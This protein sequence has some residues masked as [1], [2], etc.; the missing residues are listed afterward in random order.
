MWKHQNSPQSRHCPVKQVGAAQKASK[1]YFK[2]ILVVSNF[3]GCFFDY[4]TCGIMNSTGLVLYS[5]SGIVTHQ[6]YFF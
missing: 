5:L 4:N 1:L 3:Y 2:F 6:S